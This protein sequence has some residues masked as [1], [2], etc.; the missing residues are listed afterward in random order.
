MRLNLI[1]NTAVHREP[2]TANREQ[3]SL[4]FFN[5]SKDK[6]LF[7]NVCL[8]LLLQKFNI[9]LVKSFLIAFIRFAKNKFANLITRRLQ[10]LVL[11]IQRKAS[12]CNRTQWVKTHCYITFLT[13]ITF[14]SLSEKIKNLRLVINFKFLFQGGHSNV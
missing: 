2:R 10:P 12:Q 7:V 9:N 3:S 8:A 1:N 5:F 11:K 4:N 14:D 13:S 6:L